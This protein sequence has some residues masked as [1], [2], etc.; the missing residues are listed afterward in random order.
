MPVAQGNV[1]PTR[2]ANRHFREVSKEPPKAGEQKDFTSPQAIRDKSALG[3][4]MSKDLD[5][6]FNIFMK[7]FITQL[8]NQDPTEPMD[9]TQMTNNLLM[10]FSAA[11]QAKTNYH[12]EKLNETHETEQLAAAK[13]Y[14]N[15][16]VTY[17]GNEL[18][19]DGQNQ[20][21][22][23]DVPSG[24]KKPEIMIFD[25]QTKQRI[26]TFRL[27][28]T[29]GLQT[30]TWTGS[31]DGRDQDKVPPGQYMVKV[32]AEKDKNTW[33]DITPRMKG[34]VT[35]IDYLDDKEFV[36]YVHNTPVR[37]ED[38]Q[39]VRKPHREGD[40]QEL[41]ASLQ[42]QIASLD[43]LRSLVE[44]KA[45]SPIPVSVEEEVEFMPS[46]PV[47]SESLQHRSESKGPLDTVMDAI[48]G[49]FK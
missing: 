4:M 26:K 46:V 31:I 28:E 8:Q 39:Q 25:P 22:S 3:K 43:G 5:E 2:V 45:T 16:E 30:V 11:E 44:K 24:A 40:I 35:A 7:M 23:A 42:Q 20:T 1:L 34:T 21:I 9:G 18:T 27:S 48:T 37:F 6:Q 49:L 17:E 41:K 33:Y 36:Y 12:L 15:K 38:I 14:L 19:F 10:F 29:P 32:Q 13:S 47:L